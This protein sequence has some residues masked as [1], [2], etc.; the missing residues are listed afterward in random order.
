[1]KK[2]K[3]F[4]ILIFITS[5]AQNIQRTNTKSFFNAKGFAYIYNE[6]DFK[7]RLIKLKLDNDL[8]EISHNKLRSGALIKII[9]PKTSDEII[10]KNKK[11][12]NYPDFYKLL[13]TSKVANKLNLNFDV[14][15]IEI[16]ELKKN[17]SFVAKKTKIFNEEKKI[18]SN[19]PVDVVKIDNISKNKSVKNKAVKEK[20][21]IIVGEFYQKSTAE[22]LKERITQ[23]LTNFNSKKLLIKTNKMKK[24]SLLSGPYNSINLIKNDYILLKNFGF[25][26]LDISLN[27]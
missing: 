11:K 21:Y 4:I 20:M 5:C 12:S 2:F 10:L 22:F 24:T 16:I 25:E 23:Q 15:F 26:E 8:L 1:M 14:P 13:I 17:K 6:D 27:E 7:K 19:A 18:H 9:N 3:I